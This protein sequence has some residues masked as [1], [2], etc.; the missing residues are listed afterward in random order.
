MSAG[1]AWLRGSPGACGRFYAADPD[2]RPAAVRGLNQALVLLSHLALSLLSI[3]TGAIDFAALLKM[4]AWIGQEMLWVAVFVVPFCVGFQLAQ[5]GRP[6][7]KDER[8][9]KSK[10]E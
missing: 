4:L 3:D 10:I 2:R 5:F 9:K 8:K 7:Q 1:E 6:P